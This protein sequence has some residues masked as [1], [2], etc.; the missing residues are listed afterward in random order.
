MAI[1][2]MIKSPLVGKLNPLYYHHLYHSEGNS[3]V[4]VRFYYDD[5]EDQV[6]ETIGHWSNEWSILDNVA[7]EGASGSFLISFII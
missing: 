3:L 4:D 2:W 7:N 1:V 6:T 5:L